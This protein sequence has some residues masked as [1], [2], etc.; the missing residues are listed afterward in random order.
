[1]FE[2]S[3]AEFDNMLFLWIYGAKENDWIILSLKLESTV[4]ESQVP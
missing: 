2:I 1:M 3:F 4:E